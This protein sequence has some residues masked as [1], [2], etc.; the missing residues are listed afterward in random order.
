MSSSPVRL[1]AIDID[2]TLLS[3]GGTVTPRA[4]AA[5]RAAAQT[6][7]RICFA[8]GRSW[9]ESRHI[10][11][12]A[13]HFDIGV[14]ATGAQIVDTQRGLTLHRTMLDAGLA[15]EAAE[16]FETHGQTV[17]ALQDSEQAGVDYLVTEAT[18]L[19]PSSRNWLKMTQMVVQ[20]RGDLAAHEHSFTM[21]IS[22]VAEAR[23]VESLQ[24]EFTRQFGARAI[25]QYLIVPSSGMRVLE[26]FSPGV[27]KWEGVLHVARRHGVA[28][29]EVVAIGDDANDLSMIRGAAVGVAMGN[30]PAHVRAEAR[31]VIGDN[32]CDGLAEYLEELAGGNGSSESKARKGLALSDGRRT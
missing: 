1:V 21:R 13:G 4:R 26:V 29:E 22:I 20:R 9:R 12:M 8:T 7:L 15:R 31:R 18:P 17:L 30:A 27:N 19:N 14:F 5:V 32:G 3:P 28:P 6:G 24:E 2:G 11:E 16:F 25:C 10:V 23:D